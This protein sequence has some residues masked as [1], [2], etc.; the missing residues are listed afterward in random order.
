MFCSS[1]ITYMETR[2][3]FN[4]QNH[5]EVWHLALDTFLM[6]FFGLKRVFYFGIKGSSH[7]SISITWNKNFSCSSST[8]WHILIYGCNFFLFPIITEHARVH[9]FDIHSF[10]L[11]VGWSMFNCSYSIAVLAT[12]NGLMQIIDA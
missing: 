4:P 1:S 6:F 9:S 2:T 7:P 12:S 3:R 8:S 11:T 5:Q 10:K